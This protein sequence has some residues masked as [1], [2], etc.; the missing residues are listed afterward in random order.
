MLF[1]RPTVCQ[2]YLWE[3]NEQSIV[4]Y[5]V[6]RI[7]FRKRRVTTRVRARGT[8][9]P[10]GRNERRMRHNNERHQCRV[11]HKLQ[12][13]AGQTS[14]ESVSEGDK[15]IGGFFLDRP[16]AMASPLPLQPCFPCLFLLI[17]A[18]LF[19]SPLVPRWS[20]SFA[21]NLPTIII[22]HKW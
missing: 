13:I 1:I 3:L 14:L 6:E 5:L 15:P 8:L 22:S 2:F 7:G 12:A 19:Y 10:K 9:Q 17:C 16:E 18:R 4:A 11:R 21:N 20:T